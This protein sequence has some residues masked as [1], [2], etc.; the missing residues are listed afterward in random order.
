M[1]SFNVKHLLRTNLY[2]LDL[3]HNNAQ[4]YVRR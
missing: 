3:G 1:V 4:E 2:A